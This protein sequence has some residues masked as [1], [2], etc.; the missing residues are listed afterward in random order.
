MMRCRILANSDPRLGDPE[1][2]KAI[3]AYERHLDQSQTDLEAELQGLSKELSA[4]ESDGRGGEAMKQIA[5]RYVEAKSQI[6]KL[7]EEIASLEK[8]S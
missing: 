2:I 6:D 3:D 1:L 8:R 7:Q 5:R 4:Y